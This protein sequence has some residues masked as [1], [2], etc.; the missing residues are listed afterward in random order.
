MNHRVTRM[1]RL[2][3]SREHRRSQKGGIG[4]RERLYGQPVTHFARKHNPGQS[5]TRPTL[6]ME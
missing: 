1:S 4:D 6:D 2:R 5:N 3:S